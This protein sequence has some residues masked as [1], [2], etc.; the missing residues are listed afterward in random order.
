M[1]LFNLKGTLQSY[2]GIDSSRQAV[3]FVKGHLLAEPKLA[4][5]CRIYQGDAK[6]IRHFNT[7]SNPSLAILNSVC[8]SFPSS[9]YLRQVVEDLFHLQS[10]ETVV[11]GDM[12]SF[13][14]YR[15]FQV[16]KAVQAFGNNN[17][18]VNTF[19]EEMEQIGRSEA[20][21]LVDPGFFTGL[22]D[23]VTLSPYLH[24]I[25]ILP[26]NMEAANELSCYRYS[27]ILHTERNANNF[28]KLVHEVPGN[29]WI[30]CYER[31]LTRVS[32][33]RNTQMRCKGY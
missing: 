10:I 1:I 25:E 14:L 13:H 17:V 29:N 5:I 30:D 31:G 16:T 20:E 32:L 2:I 21:L 27:A 23:D 18:E 11:F 19:L 22:V 3:E 24:H 7:S 8:Q 4:T 9:K 6:D 33:G 12:R 15:Q 26:K 28:E